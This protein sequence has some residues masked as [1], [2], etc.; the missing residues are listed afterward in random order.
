MD[1]LQTYRDKRDFRV[2]G[3][4]KGAVGNGAG[5]RRFAVQYHVATRAHYDLRLEWDGVLLSWAVPKGFSSEPK[6]KRLA[7]KVEDHPVEYLTF[8][9]TIPKGQYGG[10]TVLLYD[11]GTFEPTVDFAA[12]LREG[13]LKFELHGTRLVGNWAL[14]RM[15]LAEKG[16]NW[17]LIK[18]TDEYVGRPVPE[19]ATGIRSGRTLDEIGMGVQVAENPFD[20]V[21]P[22]LCTAVSS[23]P[24]D[25]RLYEVKYDGYRA[26]AFCAGGKSRLISR[27]G[28]DFSARFPTLVAALNVWAGGRALVVDGEIVMTDAAGRSDFGALQ[29]G[30]SVGHNLQYVLFDLLASGGADL[31][32]LPLVERKARLRELLEGA[33]PQLTFAAHVEGRGEECLRAAASLGLEGIVGK[34]PQARY[35]S[36]RKGDWIKIKCRPRQEF[37]VGGFLRSEKTKSGIKSLL[38]GVYR[39]GKLQYVGKVGSGVDAHAAERLRGLVAERSPFDEPPKVKGESVV[40]LRPQAVAEVAFAE[41]TAE[42]L[43]RQASFL[44]LRDDKEA[45][46]VTDESIEKPRAAEGRKAAD[47]TGENIEKPRAVEVQKAAEAVKLTHP[48]RVVFAVPRTTKRDVFDYYAAAAERMLP[49]LAGRVTSVVRCH[50]GVEQGG[51]FKKHPTGQIDGVRPIEVDEHTYFTIESAAGLLGEVQAGSVEFHVWG[52]RTEQIERPDCMVF[53]LDPDEGLPLQSLRRG[54]RDLKA[55]LEELRLPAFL[56]TSGGK[57]YHV[58]VPFAATVDWES[59]R[60]FARDVAVLLTERYPDRY[61]A[62]MR[63]IARKGKIFIDWARNTRGATSVAPY[64]LRARPGAKVAMPIAWDELDDVTPDFF[65]LTAALKR[66]RE[67]DP[68]AYFSW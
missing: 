16:D 7:V 34:K 37:V 17:L 24:A 65:D 41:R 62:N 50:D 27:N 49:F 25:D 61:T 13:S 40:W 29:A 45:A 44:G 14:V 57:G 31:R 47:V 66:L 21:M 6:D 43:L 23:V 63:K 48:D 46:D 38:L 54:V 5:A 22:A 42:G 11:V 59:F 32:D 1:S 67:P 19:P 3:E 28:R 15:K 33:P 26:V 53:D 36:G 4:P 60:A 68:W 51:F 58:V 12:G 10:G 35:V 39:D 18:E 30:E 20:T 52:S 56:K 9:G 8:E 2:T 64:S 55:V